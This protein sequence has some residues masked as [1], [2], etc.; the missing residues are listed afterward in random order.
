MGY[1]THSDDEVAARREEGEANA[2]WQ[3]RRQM[4]NDEIEAGR[5]PAPPRHQPPAAEVSTPA[6][7]HIFKVPSEDEQAAA[8]QRFATAAAEN[9]K[10]A[11]AAERLTFPCPNCKAEPGQKCKNYVGT[12]C[13]THRQRG[14]L[15][16][17]L[18][19]EPRATPITLAA[20]TIP[21]TCS[22]R[23]VDGHTCTA[24][25]TNDH[26][27]TA[28]PLCKRHAREARSIADAISGKSQVPQPPPPVVILEDI[29]PEGRLQAQMKALLSVYTI[30]TIID[31]AW[32]ADRAAFTPGQIRQPRAAL[33]AATR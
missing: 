1:R 13:G 18:T 16:E 17:G 33:K 19:A 21:N 30:S 32:E 3:Q 29:T 15:P 27:Q 4:Q 7:R 8:R 20:C 23:M 5:A 9:L 2:A 14:K 11:A 24:K 28:A 22:H 31:A 26:W 10:Q 6:S 12:N 25:A